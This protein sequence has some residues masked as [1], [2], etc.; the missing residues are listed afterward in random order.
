MKTKIFFAAVLVLIIAGAY[1]LRPT[2]APTEVK[3]TQQ[4]TQTQIQYVPP[5]PPKASDIEADLNAYRKQDG[6]APLADSPTLDRAARARANNMCAENNW[7]HDGDWATLQQYYLYNSAGENLYYGGL[8]EDQAAKAV[9]DWVHSPEHLE[10][11]V[12]SYTEFGIA[13]K[14]CPGFQGTANAILI[15]NY[16]G[17]P[18]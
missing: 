12:G 5:K 16:F 15:T 11:I 7:S 8:Q 10:N 2:H 6:L 13:V 9:H 3:S 4:P 18:R 1:A 14:V 17:V